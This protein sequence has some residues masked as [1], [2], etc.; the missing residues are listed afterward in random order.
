[1]SCLFVLFVSTISNYNPLMA[2]VFEHFRITT[3][4][5]FG[6][7]SMHSITTPQMA[8]SLFLKVT[9]EGDHSESIFMTLARKW[10][11]F[12]MRINANEGLAEKQLV[13][14]FLNRM[15]KFYKSKGIRLMET[16]EID[17]FIHAIVEEPARRHHSDRETTCQGRH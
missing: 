11:Q 6:V 3:L 13:N 9:M 8:Y 2:D 16:N 15:G 7:D 5:A 14:V 4:N 1:M 12:I 17:D 10:A